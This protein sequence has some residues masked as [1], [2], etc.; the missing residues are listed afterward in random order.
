VDLRDVLALAELRGTLPE[1]TLAMGLEPDQ[2]V[3][4]TG[5]S[6]TLQDG[7]DDLVGAVVR[8]LDAWGHACALRTAP[9]HA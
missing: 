6:E 7:L 2:V 8:Q 3:L 5:L 9:V 4:R 1:E